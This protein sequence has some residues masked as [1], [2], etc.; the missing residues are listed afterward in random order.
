MSFFD[1]S[2]FGAFFGGK[3][4]EKHPGKQ[5]LTG[6]PLAQF[7]AEMFLSI[8][9]ALLRKRMPVILATQLRTAAV[10]GKPPPIERILAPAN[11]QSTRQAVS[12]IQSRDA[13]DASKRAALEGVYSALTGPG[14]RLIDLG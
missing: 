14:A 12:T 5:S 6:A 7:L 3:F 1:C 9:A 8:R 13:S 4:F 2:N 11:K 10:L